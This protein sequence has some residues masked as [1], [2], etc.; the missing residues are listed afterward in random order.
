MASGFAFPLFR[1]SS[2]PSGLQGYWKLDEGSGTRA[3][4]SG[5]GNTL[6]DN[7]TVASVAQDYWKTGENS[8]DFESANSEYL[9]IADGSQTG[10]D[11]TANLTISGFVKLETG[12]ITHTIVSKGNPSAGTGWGLRIDTSNRLEM[13]IG[14]SQTT[15]GTALSVGKWQHFA[16]SF[17]STANTIAYYIDGNLV[18]VVAET[19]NLADNAIEFRL[20]TQSNSANYFDGLQKDIALHSSALTP[21]QIKSLALGVD[22]STYAYRPNNVST[23]PTAWWKMNELSGNR[24][25]STSGAKTLTDNNTVTASSGY[26]EGVG[27]FFTAANS[28]YFS[29]ADS[30]DW[31]FGTGDFSISCWIKTGADI[32]DQGFIAQNQDGSNGWDFYISGVTPHLRFKNTVGAATTIDLDVVWTGVTTN[33]IYHLAVKRSGNDFSVWVDGVQMGAT[34]TD[35]SEVS[36]FTGELWIGRNG[37]VVGTN[38][39][40]GSMSDVAI[41]KGYALTDAEIKSLAC[42]IPLQQTGIVSYWKLDET[43]GTRAD[44]IGANNLTDNNTVLS[45]TGKVSNAADFESSNSEYLSIADNSSL[46]ITSD[47]TILTWLKPESTGITNTM[48]YKIGT[49]PDSGYGMFIESGTNTVNFQINGVASNSTSTVSA[50]TFYHIVGLYDGASKKVYFNSVQEDN[51]A[52]TTNP[53]DNA[54]DLYIGR[55]STFYADGLIDEALIAQRWFRDEEI[56]TI[57]CKGLAGKELTS[58]EIVLGGNQVIWTL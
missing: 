45:G 31:Y 30:A 27:A 37:G 52:Y 43:S 46:S 11:F 2:I 19:T 23:Q 14:A 17:D 33:T 36:N 25:D 7:N 13:N 51:D 39:F 4:S 42:G 48:F 57:Y 50:G 6:T 16:M 1:P 55:Q 56:K 32:A 44:S 29:T 35:T 49:G 10:L 20:G 18:A 41:W 47:L 12:S 21:I 38:Y 53:A 3:D 34:L 8:A 9:S 5:N 15:S 22:L 26:V 54:L 28:E 58:S 24:S 40:G